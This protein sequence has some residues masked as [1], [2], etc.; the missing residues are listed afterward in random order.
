MQKPSFSYQSGAIILLSLAFLQG[1]LFLW[2]TPPWWHYDEP[3]RFERVWMLAHYADRGRQT[4]LQDTDLEMHRRIIESM[5][6]YDWFHH[7]PHDQWPDPSQPDSL[8]I[9]YTEYTPQLLY[10]FIVSLPLRF[11]ETWAPENQLRLA[12]L[13]SVIM[14]VLTVGAAWGALG[15]VF[16]S[17]HPL[18]WLIPAFLA[19]LPGF[20][21]VM[22]SVNDDVGA[23]LTGALFLWASLRILRRGLSF[24][25][26]LALGLTAAAAFW[27]KNTTWPLLLTL[28]WTVWFGLPW[29]SRRLPWLVALTAGGLAG[30]LVLRWDAPILWFQAKA[31]QDLP[32]RT[33]TAQAPL[34]E[35]AFSFD[36][37]GPDIGQWIPAATARRLRDHP[38]TIGV[39]LW[40]ETPTQMSLPRLCVRSGCTPTQNV[41]VTSQPQ[42]FTLT[43]TFP[44]GRYP[45]LI[46]PHPQTPGKVF[47]DG[48][49]LVQGAFHGVPS[50]VSPEGDHILWEGH[51]VDNELRNASAERVGP[52]LHPAIQRRLL[53]KFP[54]SLDLALATLLDPK[55]S[56][57]LQKATLVPLYRTFWGHLA[58]S[59]V[60][61][62]GGTPLYRFLLILSLAG[63]AGALGAVWA[64]RRAFPWATGGFLLLAMLGP[65]LTAYFRGLGTGGVIL[66]WARYA[67]PA[68]LPTALLLCSGWYFGLRALFSR[69][70]Q[71]ATQ[72]A[73]VLLAFFLTLSIVGWL[74]LL[75]YF[76]PNHRPWVFILFEASLFVLML[77]TILHLRAKY[78]S[79]GQGER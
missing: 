22:T 76:Y 57:A 32:L 5:L 72:V 77:W 29:R 58:R 7:Y 31:P 14:L 20:L 34:G 68:I 27:T 18:R 49:L 69:L 46:L 4:Q 47:A 6:K 2:L 3:Q 50:L 56:A 36:S 10:H 35:W 33:R 26:L 24:T 44:S 15:E 11:V 60:D 53:S 21:D 43:T 71:P 30:V 52:R 70:G 41:Q 9:I 61:L 73:P 79:P 67:S 25:R 45:R 42:F 55:G 59:K 66:P 74:S 8:R 38:V 37:T 78:A 23:A 51:K 19:T 39:W 40:S 54:A 13:I 63:L 62:L 17:S 16:P 48:I 1:L 64:H 28:P 75:H 65:W 12:R